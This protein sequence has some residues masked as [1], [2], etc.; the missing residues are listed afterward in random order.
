MSSSGRRSADKMM[1][2]KTGSQSFGLPTNNDYVK[3]L[4]MTAGTNGFTCLPPARWQ[5]VMIDGHPSTVRPRKTETEEDLCGSTIGIYTEN[6][7]YL[8]NAQ[9][10]R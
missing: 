2:M 5:L 1:M 4:Q 3:D 8:R 10:T 6:I 9:V 7:T